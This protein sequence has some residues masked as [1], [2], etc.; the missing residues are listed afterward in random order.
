MNLYCTLLVANACAETGLYNTQQAGD[1][2]PLSVAGTVITVLCDPGEF[3]PDG[4]TAMY[5]AECTAAVWND[6]RHCGKSLAP[7]CPRIL[8]S[9]LC[10]VEVNISPGVVY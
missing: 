10:N 5:Y 9:F 1:V 8:V 7:Y 2:L 4:V 6:T 3:L